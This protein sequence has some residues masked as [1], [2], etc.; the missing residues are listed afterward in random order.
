MDNMTINERLKMLRTEN[1]LTQTELAKK[2]GI[3]QTT[4]AAYEKS[5]D[6]NIY[7]LI[8]YADFF[9]CSLD[10]LA[11]REQAPL[12]YALSPQEREL[13]QKFRSLKPPI[14]S[15]AFEQLK[16]LSESEINR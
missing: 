14:R 15:F 13:V 3:A 12:P 8:A 16:L 5:H 6:P 11:G 10:Y 1:D 7:S 2:L 4:V 9:E